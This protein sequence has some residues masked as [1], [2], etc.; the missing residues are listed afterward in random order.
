MS[1]EQRDVPPERTPGGTVRQAAAAARLGLAAAPGA[2]LTVLGLAVVEGALPPV[3]AWFTKLLV[4]ELA[5]GQ[6]AGVGRVTAAAVGL[7]VAGLLAGAHRSVAFY[8]AGAMSRAARLLAADRLFARVNGYVGLDRFENPAFLD[9]LRLAV[10]AGGQAPGDLTRSV[11]ALIRA[12]VQGGGFLATLVVVWPPIVL[13][14]LAGAVP[15][16]LLQ[17]RAGRRRAGLTMSL[18]PVHRR[19]FTYQML[20]TDVSAAK[21]IRLFGLGDFLRG[22]MLGE[23]RAG[24][25]AEAGLERR[26]LRMDAGL[27][28]LAGAVMVTGVAVAAYR[29]M[30]GLITL[31]DVTLFLAALAGVYGAVTAFTESAATAYR[32]LLLFGAYQAIVDEPVPAPAAAPDGPRP[33]RTGIELRDVWFRYRDD[34]PW[35][36]RGV[37]LVIP[38]GASVGLV[39]VNGA[40]KSTL[41]KLLCRLY[42]PQRGRILWDGADI[43][44]IAPEDL[45]SRITAVFQDFMTYDLTARENIG[46]GRLDALGDLGAIRRAARP[47]GVDDALA[48][49]PHGY[50]TLL[51]R[52]FVGLDDDSAQ[53]SGGQWQRVAVARAFLREDADLMIL[54]EPSSGLDPEAEHALHERLMSLTTGRT[55]LLIS[56]RL[57]ALRDADEIVVLDGGRIV[58][59]GPHTALL[60]HGGVYARLFALQSAAYRDAPDSAALAAE[61]G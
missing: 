30:H 7:A 10:Q 60:E 20:L 51:S 47:A 53:L 55:S 14:V 26:L 13:A 29:A 38:R 36:L 17:A 48:A 34:G 59:R 22:R 37:D 4:D 41:I 3:T 39:G 40:G 42:E 5:R 18:S 54:D 45:R 46:V 43:R 52:I 1:G 15:A 28:L 21:E 44:T 11:V 23:L 33:L 9:R 50:D 61:P 56:H 49:L 16:A 2:M 8:L 25:D 19:E 24:N 35:V 6:A 12:M 27:E 31:G 57:G 58:E 32:A